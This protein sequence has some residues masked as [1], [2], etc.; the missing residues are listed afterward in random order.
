MG[1]IVLRS[2]D[3]NA[4]SSALTKRGESER[5]AN[6]SF[7]TRN[8]GREGGGKEGRGGGR[9]HASLVCMERMFAVL[10]VCRTGFSERRHKVNM[11]C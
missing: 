11:P 1:H 10:C 5:E 8:G 2:H 4:M 7:S 6:T 3:P 9:R